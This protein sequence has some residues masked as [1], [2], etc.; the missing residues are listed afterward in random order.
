MRLLRRHPHQ[1]LARMRKSR[2]LTKATAPQYLAVLFMMLVSTAGTGIAFT[3]FLPFATTTH[4]LFERP[5]SIPL[6]AMLGD[7]DVR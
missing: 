2:R 6:W 5:W 4:E 3:G 7:F 1:S